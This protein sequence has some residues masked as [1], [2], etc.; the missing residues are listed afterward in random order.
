MQ[1]DIYLDSEPSKTQK[2][3]IINATRVHFAEKI[4]AMKAA[5][6]R[7]TVA[8]LLLLLFGAALL[9]VC[10]LSQL[11][12]T[13]EVFTN[14]IDILA[15]VLVWDAFEK[16][17]FERKKDTTEQINNFRIMKARIVFRPYE[18]QYPAVAVVDDEVVDEPKDEN[19]DWQKDDTNPSTLKRISRKVEKEIKKPPLPKDSN[20]FDLPNLKPLD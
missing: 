11:Y 7:N 3:N 14:L 4:A 18:K 8:A 9:I 15:W 12:E 16:L 2:T 5:S 17:I 6:K 1:L 10:F 13:N 19:E 20:T